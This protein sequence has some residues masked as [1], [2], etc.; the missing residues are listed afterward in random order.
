MKSRILPKPLIRAV[1]FVVE[2]YIFSHQERHKR[3]IPY[4]IILFKIDLF[5]V[6]MT[7]LKN[8]LKM[9]KFEFCRN[10]P[11]QKKK[12]NFPYHGGSQ[13]QVN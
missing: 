8:V 3:S 11:P 1:D 5:P 2:P 10:H 9:A 13:L 6:T 12:K 7:E 4:L